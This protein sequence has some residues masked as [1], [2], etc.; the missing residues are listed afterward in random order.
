MRFEIGVQG[1]SSNARLRSASEVQADGSSRSREVTR[2]QAE[3]RERVGEVGAPAVSHGSAERPLGAATTSCC[4]ATAAAR[5]PWSRRR[6]RFGVG[7][8]VG[9]SEALA[10]RCSA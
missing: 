8:R 7:M 6:C 5:R 9:V 10:A 1:Q 2:V 4:G 3:V